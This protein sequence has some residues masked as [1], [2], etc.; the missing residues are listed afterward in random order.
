MRR[1][2]VPVL[3]AAL[4]GLTAP[5]AS[6]DTGGTPTATPAPEAVYVVARSWPGYY[7]TN[8]QEVWAVSPD[9]ARRE[10]VGAVRGTVAAVGPTGD[11]VAAWDATDDTTARTL[12]VSGLDGRSRR[13]VARFGAD[14]FGGEVSWSADGTTLLVSEGDKLWLAHVDGEPPVEVAHSEG[15]SGAAFDPHD[16]GAYVASTGRQV[17]H[18]RLGEVPVPVP[19]TESEGSTAARLSPDGS[20]LAF[21]RFRWTDATHKTAVNDVVVQALDGS[22]QTVLSSTEL[23]AGTTWSAD[24]TSL[25]GLRG[26]NPPGQSFGPADV[27][28]SPLDGSVAVDVTETPDLD[29]VALMGVGTRSAWA[30][31]PTVNSIELAASA[32]TL[33]FT[34]ATGTTVRVYT[35]PS[36]VP[37]AP[38]TLVADAATSPL[39]VPVEPDEAVTLTLVSIDASGTEVGR[40]VAHA[41]AVRPAVVTL[42]PTTSTATADLAFPVSFFPPDERLITSYDAEYAVRSPSGALSAWTT[43][44]QTGSFAPARPGTT[45]VLRA[46]VHDRFGNAGGWVVGPAASVPFD[47]TAGRYSAGWRLQHVKSRFLGTLHTTSRPGFSVVFRGTGSQLRLVGDRGPTALRFRVYV[48]GRAVAVVDPRAARAAVR[49]VLWSTHG[50]RRGRHVVKVVALKTP[51]GRTLALDGFVAAP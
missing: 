46:R 35:S 33:S 23:P 21:S 3:S 7:D 14:S 29:E 32:L 30:A 13:A 41:E 5:P 11:R 20:R 28:R 8:V 37:A 51:H 2:I 18:A 4:L 50:L 16:S 49:K 44:Q 15:L 9:G 6:A 17:V 48:D 10:L 27:F 12:F 22:Q 19:G 31:A 25:Y 43:Y 39:A 47:D 1:T 34:P 26:V 40:A 24:G 36:L 42:P 38:G 45:Y